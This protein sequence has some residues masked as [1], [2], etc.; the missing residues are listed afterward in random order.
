MQM[1]NFKLLKRFPKIVKIWVNPCDAEEHLEVFLAIAS[2][3]HTFFETKS[4]KLCYMK[5]H[6]DIPKG[7]IGMQFYNATK[8]KWEEIRLSPLEELLKCVSRRGD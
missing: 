5:P 2:K 6:Y 4:K 3:W 1:T 7:Q 8:K